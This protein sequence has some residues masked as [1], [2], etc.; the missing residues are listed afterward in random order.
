MKHRTRD[1]S[2]WPDR[3]IRRLVSRRE[4]LAL[5]ALL[6]WLTFA[7]SATGAPGLLVGVSDNTLKEHPAKAAPVIADLGLM[8]V[9]LTFVWN[10][11]KTSL[12]AEDE[13]NLAGAIAA[14]PGVKIFVSAYSRTTTP[15]TEKSRA[16]YCAYLASF[17]ARFPQVSYVVV[18]N[19]ANKSTFWR[20]QFADGQSAAPADYV[21][22]LAEC[23]DAVKAV[24]PSI[25]VIGGALSSTG[26][27]NPNASSNV[28]HSPGN[29]VRRMGEAYRASGRARPVFDW[30]GIHAYGESSVESPAKLHDASSTIAMGDMNTFL[31]ALYDGFQGTGQPIVARTPQGSLPATAVM[32]NGFQTTPGSGQQAYIGS[33]NVPTVPARP[34]VRAPAGGAVTQSTQ[35]VDAI[36]IAYC[37]PSVGAYFNFLLADEPDLGR[38]QSGVLWT[39]WKKKPSYDA[40]KSII[41]EVKADTVDCAGLPASAV[42]AFS[43][44]RALEVTRVAWPSTRSFNWKN[45]LWRF[46]VQARESA[47]YTATL[48][49]IG[50]SR[51]VLTAAGKLK[52]LYFS[53]VTFPR[54]RIPPGRYEIR[55]A[56]AS[57]ETPGRQATLRSPA[58]VVESRAG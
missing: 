46:R 25:T 35:L 14:A 45:D 23:Y 34:V 52:K 29:F 48:I 53:F 49:R 13:A 30:L 39:D 9:R 19:E 22:L 50:S 44:K 10:P 5:L 40:L 2:G 55:V 17:P 36:R 21:A 56:L 42:A 47:I 27:D 8:A 28:S 32:E 20:P 12:T 7:A 1:E 11:D 54:K 3:S 18:W 37:H 43:P 16:A 31:Q 15:L 33:E 24:R 38:W 26:N 4:C 41:A 51:P 57:A 6:A 58:F